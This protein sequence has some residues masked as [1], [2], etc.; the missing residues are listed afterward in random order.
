MKQNKKY[1]NQFV[2]LNSRINFIVVFFGT[3]I[4]ANFCLKLAK[5]FPHD[6]CDIFSSIKVFKENQSRVVAFWKDCTFPLI[7]EVLTHLLSFSMSARFSCPNRIVNLPLS[8]YL[9]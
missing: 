5:R 4:P 3:S 2:T 1:F 7:R 9:N 6:F 8:D